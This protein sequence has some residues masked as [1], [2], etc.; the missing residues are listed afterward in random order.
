[1]PT[2]IVG[3]LNLVETELSACLMGEMQLMNTI[4]LS[5]VKRI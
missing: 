3:K 1:M 4:E 5:C 2:F